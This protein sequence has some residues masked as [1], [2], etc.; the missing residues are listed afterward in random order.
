M[1]KFSDLTP[2]GTAHIYLDERGRGWIDDT[3]MRVDQVVACVTGVRRMMPEELV[4][5]YPDLTLAGVHAAMAWYYDHR[6]AVDALFAEESRLVEAGR[7]R[8][9]DSPQH[10]KLMA[11]K[12]A[13]DAAATRPS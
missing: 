4:A 1:R 5:A 9:K 10:R 2:S 12:A 3:G 7:A 6:P 13:R 8:N 11:A